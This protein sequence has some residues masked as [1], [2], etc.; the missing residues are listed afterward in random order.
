MSSTTRLLEAPIPECRGHLSIHAL[1]LDALRWSSLVALGV[2]DTHESMSSTTAQCA[3]T[4]MLAATEARGVRNATTTYACTHGARQ[5]DIG[6]RTCRLSSWITSRRYET[7]GHDSAHASSR[8]VA[9][10]IPSRPGRRS[11][12]AQESEFFQGGGA[13]TTAPTGSVCNGKMR[14]GGAYGW[15]TW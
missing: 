15:T 2:N 6:G 7:E 9:H 10:A 8:C 4:A 3:A 11:G 13:K 1:R 12:P 5:N 14:K